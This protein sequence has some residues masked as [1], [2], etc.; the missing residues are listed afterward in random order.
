MRGGFGTIERFFLHGAELIVSERV[1]E[2]GTEVVL[3][4]HG[5]EERTRTTVCVCIQLVL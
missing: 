5:N 4:T 3:R 2:E 1:L